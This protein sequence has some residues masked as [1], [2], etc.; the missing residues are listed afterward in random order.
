[1]AFWTSAPDDEREWVRKEIADLLD[2]GQNALA[3]FDQRAADDNVR[4]KIRKLTENMEGRSEAEKETAR[5]RA[6]LCGRSC[7]R[8]RPRKRPRPRQPR[9]AEPTPTIRPDRTFSQPRAAVCLTRY[10]PGQEI[11]AAHGH[12]GL[13][14]QP[15]REAR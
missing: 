9:I 10:S 12:K 2:W 14:R 1:M 7:S 8:H 4:E 6:E 3:A 5:G 13:R 15:W 11:G